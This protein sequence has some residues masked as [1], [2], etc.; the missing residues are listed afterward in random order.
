MLILSQDRKKITLINAL[1]CIEI[2]HDGVTKRDVNGYWSINAQEVF[3]HTLGKYQTEER[4]VQVLRDIFN[5]IENKYIM[6]E[7]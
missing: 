4:A 6:P 1:A 3:E 5:C 7:K 2:R